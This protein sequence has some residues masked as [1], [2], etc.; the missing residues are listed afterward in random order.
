MPDPSFD[1]PQGQNDPLTDMISAA[2]VADAKRYNFRSSIA[3]G[4]MQNPD[5][6]AKAQDVAG[7]L[8]TKPQAVIGD[9]S[10]FEKA[11]RRNAVDFDSFIKHAPR[12]T[13]WLSDPEKAAIAND[14]LHTLWRLEHTVQNRPEGLTDSQWQALLDD[15]FN[16][17]KEDMD[18]RK[19]EI[20]S[21][22][23]AGVGGLYNML[24]GFAYK[25]VPSAMEAVSSIPF[26]VGQ[27][28][29]SSQ[30]L[31]ATAR[32]IAEAF[33]MHPSRDTLAGAIAA[34]ASQAEQ[35]IA[36]FQKVGAQRLLV[37]S[38]TGKTF[39]NPD[40]LT[41]GTSTPGRFLN[42]VLNR[43]AANSLLG[44]PG[45]MAAAALNPSTTASLMTANAGHEKY[46]E[47]RKQGADFL[48]GL[49]EGAGSAGLNWLLMN[50][51]PHAVPTQTA[52]GQVG[53]ALG[54]GVTLGTGMTV[55]ENLLAR[56]HD[57]NR[58]LTEGAAGQIANFIGFEVGGTLPRLIQAAGSSKLRTRSPEAFKSAV[59]HL[60]KET[61]LETV[62]VPVEKLQTFFQS[63]GMDPQKTAEALGARNYSEAL[64]AGTDVI[65]PMADLLAKMKPEQVRELS[66][67]MRFK[68]SE[69]TPRELEA[70]K[71]EAS[72]PDLKTQAEP[73]EPGARQIIYED[74]RAQLLD[75]G[76]TERVADILADRHARVMVNMA[77]DLGQ[78]PLAVHE[79]FGLRIYRPSPGEGQ[80]PVDISL[81]RMGEGA[82]V[83]PPETT[84]E[85]ITT[86][87][88]FISEFFQSM[89]RRTQDF[90]K[91]RARGEM[92]RSLTPS[93]QSAEL[94]RRAEAAKAEEQ[95]FLDWEK[96][97]KETQAGDIFESKR[98]FIQF[99]PDRK[100]SIALLE[101][102]DLST[103]TH[104]VGH[105]YLEVMGDLATAEG[106]KGTGVEAYQKVLNFLGVDE[107]SKLTTEH[108]EKFAKALETYAM[109]GKAPTPE[110]QSAFQRVKFWMM[111]VYRS[112]SDLGVKLN[113]EIRGVFDRMYA[114]DEAITRAEKVVNVEPLF[115]TAEEMG[116]PQSIFDAYLKSSRSALES[117]KAAVEAKLVREAKREKEAWW[118]EESAKVRAEVTAEVDADPTYQAFKALADGQLPNG[119]PIKLSKAALEAQFGKGV[120]KDLPR[121]FQRLYSLEGGLDAE[122]VAELLGFDS[123]SGMVEA[124]K[125]LEPRKDRIEALTDARMKA[126][127]GDMLT[128]GTIADAAI[129]A[130][131][132]EAFDEMR[133]AELKIL[134][135]KARELGPA[136]ELKALKGEMR[137]QARDRGQLDKAQAEM[138]RQAEAQN[139]S[140]ARDAVETLPP[141]QAFRDAAREIVSQTSIRDLDPWRYLQASHKASR[142]SFEAMGR[143]QYADAAEAKSKEILNRHL[144]LEASK[145]KEEAGRI[146]EYGRKG[147]DLR[148]Q[149]ILGKAGADFQAQWNNLAT[150]YDFAKVTNRALD[151]QVQSLRDWASSLVD[152]GAVIDPVLLE[153]NL[154]KNWRT[155]P[156]VELQALYDGLR[157]IETVA[158]RQLQMEVDGKRFDFERDAETM[159]QWA[160]ERLKSKPVPRTGT[161][162]SFG[163]K[164]GRWIQGADAYQTK[165]EWLID[166][167]DG[168]DINGPWRRNI[169]APIDTA[170]GR[171][172]ALGRKV[173]EL[174]KAAVER[175]PAEDRARELDS[176]GVTFP[177]MDRPMT[178]AQLISWVLNL[179]TE[180]NR[181][182]A[183]LGEEL[184]NADATLKLEVGQALG[185]L[186]AADCRFIQDIWDSLETLR[187][188]IIAKERRVTGIEP[189]W[190]HLTPFTVQTT[191]G[192]TVH[193][194]GGY[195][196]L[197]ADYEVSDVGRIQQDPS[198]PEGSFSRPTTSRS[199]TKE[200]TGATYPLLLDYQHVLGKHLPDVVKDVT[201]S[202]AI[203][204]VYKF[205]QNPK[206]EAAVA[207]T[208]G[209]KYQA[210][211]LPWLQAV[212]GKSTDDASRNP[213]VQ[214]LLARRSGMVAARLAG[215]LSS[216]LV[217]VGDVLKPWT[218]LPA[219]DL[220]KAFFDVRRNPR[221]MIE[222]IRQLSPNEMAFREENFN[223]DIKDML[224]TKTTLEE[225]RQVVTEFLMDGFRV[226]DRLTSF[227]AWLAAYRVG[228]KTHGNEGQAIME[229]D[230]LISRTMQA[231][232]PRNMSRMLREQGLMRLF[233]TFGG[234]ANTWYGIL[235]SA[236]KS[237]N[238]R[239][240]SVAVMALFLDQIVA[241]TLRGRLPQKD[242]H[243][244]EWTTEQALGALFNPFGFYGDMGQY[245]VK[246]AAG[247]YAKF[248]NPTMQAFEKALTLPL[249]VS[250]YKAGKQDAE[251][252]AIDAV[253]AVGTWFGAPGTGQ[254]V[255][256]WKYQHQLRTGKQPRP[257]SKLDEL[258]NT[259]F[260]PPPKEK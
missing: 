65:L 155:V 72:R 157:N 105:M 2:S 66:Q 103:F 196:P 131:H 5:E 244:G 94:T 125:T 146:A 100:V 259:L 148:F 35:S 191:D 50:R 223:R 171:E 165:M 9:L 203:S 217:Q 233:T 95:A 90:R 197:K 104:E 61:P 192:E 51:V 112:I 238:V 118:R 222:Q 27:F 218:E 184:V 14:D 114:G 7:Q 248:T 177:K 56:L 23:S 182:V 255:R 85:T 187:P 62:M 158:R 200:V 204:A 46:V 251:S 156:L 64:A 178:K 162:F 102:S 59:E 152:D 126:Q 226:M 111:Q 231:G 151:Q 236:V 96:G 25:T 144:Y 213:L 229:A 256:S 53:Q 206:I 88:G 119:T 15:R 20:Y 79:R 240:V 74:T 133:W 224:G 121:A 117:A 67:D 179:G 30:T 54:R 168:G 246:K 142:E 120:G 86:D 185:K 55:G 77:T 258:R 34:G 4:M 123:G 130:L 180:E 6:R 101:G 215:N 37:D 24:S 87:G 40:F 10:N 124:L 232:E 68:H 92:A 169:K 190:K 63:Q 230:R 31:D 47:A 161:Q 235:S 189:K 194:R 98:G 163:E 209:P 174:L 201:M 33:K 99:S 143:D 106:A 78:D 199:H 19:K 252:L 75:A 166:R 89:K 16:R 41:F 228:L 97:V 115:T 132:N 159:D 44:A 128:D 237:Q 60:F 70:Y 188:E 219:A 212:A 211:F 39:E 221:E 58:D 17:F 76:N 110:L 45:I 173:A 91:L 138:D 214:F 242:D 80:S 36:S 48:T 260:G 13:E 195:Y 135:K 239:R 207:E 83:A 26:E 249:S 150:R 136:L 172:K 147:S 145:A 52:L 81:G 32:R 22:L 234:D 137:Q 82:T 220:A 38:A 21:G 113:P 139:R 11:A 245:A 175:R 129:E 247:Q 73:V 134:R 170:S 183:L 216:Y 208:L 227:P 198:L 18:P 225:K 29:T 122:T 127:H 69:L 3:F 153:G 108:H 254:A 167:L 84:A 49:E 109:E 116:V 202:E 154:P 57:P 250:R 186:S 243:W 93:G 253:D 8:G 164:A 140:F 210:E 42:E 160:R 149:G 141:I 241:S 205:I 107:R 181:H 257:A 43:Q 28:L 12:A 71:A 1:T 176:T 193:M